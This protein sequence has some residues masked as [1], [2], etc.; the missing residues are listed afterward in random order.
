MELR[1]LLLFFHVAGVVVWVGGMFFAYVCL[2]PV[3]AAQLDAP[4]RLRLWE[5]VFLRFFP[6][7][8]VSVLMILASGIAMLVHVGMAAAPPHWHAMMAVGLLMMAIFM[9]VY[10][11]PFRRLRRAVA[12]GQWPDGGHALAQIRQLVGIN[13]SLG[14]VNILIATLGWWFIR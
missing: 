10:F 14:L 2:R 3:A 5:G 4:T 1:P 11:A 6:W 7:V 9:H 13:L 12:A 8:W